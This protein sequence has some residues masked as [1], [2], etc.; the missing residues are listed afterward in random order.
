MNIYS[1][2]HQETYLT[3][4]S[5]RQPFCIRYNNYFHGETAASV[6]FSILKMYFPDRSYKY[7]YK[8]CNEQETSFDALQQ[9]GFDFHFFEWDCMHAQQR[10]LLSEALEHMTSLMLEKN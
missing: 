8:A 2:E 9:S 10:K 1:A 4:I 5:K 3:S 6:V 7:L